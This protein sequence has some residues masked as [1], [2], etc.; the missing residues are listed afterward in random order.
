[1]AVLS[2]TKPEALGEAY[3]TLRKCVERFNAGRSRTREAAKKR[4]EGYLT[5][6]LRRSVRFAQI[7]EY[8]RKAVLDRTPYTSPI[9]ETE[10]PADAAHRLDR[11]AVLQ[12]AIAA[13]PPIYRDAIQNQRAPDGLSKSALKSRQH[14]ARA[15]LREALLAAGFSWPGET[16]R[17]R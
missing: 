1:M 2:R 4:F 14:R 9:N 13:L 3:L 16:E 7:N 11:S 5:T 17:P 10:D 6:S 15:M 12:R 8:R